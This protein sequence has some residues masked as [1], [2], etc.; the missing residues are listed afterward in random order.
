MSDF[1]DQLLARS[2]SPEVPSAVQPRPVTRF[3]TPEWS[4]L[5][6]TSLQ[7]PTP[8]GEQ[9][10][11]PVQLASSQVNRSVPAAFEANP[12]AIQD[13]STSGHAPVDIGR[14]RL[15]QTAIE[16]AQLPD[17]MGNVWD[18]MGRRLPD[19]RPP[20]NIDHPGR[21]R[22][23]LLS[24]PE[25]TEVQPLAIQP[26]YPEP[27]HSQRSFIPGD[28]LLAPPGQLEPRRET[29]SQATPAAPAIVQL[30]IGR[31]E[32]NA[33][34]AP[35][36]PAPAHRAPVIVRPVRSLDDYLEQRNKR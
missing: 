15:A 36:T 12:Q 18:Q 14:S 35:S 20:E 11:S 10:A 9:V 25:Q 23:I 8:E 27:Q 5:P 32:V 24:A 28:R 2:Y 4:E 16:P 29:Q 13:R 30:T 26:S 22:E 34:A 33:P 17:D 1:L 19:E 21:V 31:I 3:E 7:T 6:L